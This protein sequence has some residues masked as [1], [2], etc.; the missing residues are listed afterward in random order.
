MAQIIDR[1]MGAAFLNVATYE[2]VEADTTATSQAAMVVLL[3]AIAQ[4]IGGVGHGGTGIIVGAIAA[5]LGWLG[6]LLSVSK[7]LR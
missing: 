5:L 2:E 3:G 6:A 7:Y 1:M 4:A